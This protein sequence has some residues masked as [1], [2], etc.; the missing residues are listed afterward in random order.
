MYHRECC[1]VVPSPNFG[2]TR[3]EMTHILQQE[4][5]DILEFRKGHKNGTITTRSNY[6]LQRY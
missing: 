1:D 2:Y 4:C 3:C 6:A 5:R